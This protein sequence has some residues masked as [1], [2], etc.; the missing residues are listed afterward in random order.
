M[1]RVTNGVPQGSVL[2]PLHFLICINDLPKITG[3]DAKVVLFADDTSIIVTISNQGR[4]P[5]ALKKICL[6]KS[7]G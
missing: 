3:N 6:V 1:E 7:H 2:V 5:T 4:L